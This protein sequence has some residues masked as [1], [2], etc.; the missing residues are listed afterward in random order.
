MKSIH[1]LRRGRQ[2]VPRQPI[3]VALSA[4]GLVLLMVTA[5]ACGGAG[6]TS[7]STDGPN[8][9]PQRGG[10]LRVMQVTEPRSLDP[11][12]VVNAQG[13]GEVVANSLY[14]T[15]VTNDPETGD[16]VYDMAES[17]ESTDG[18]TSWV[19]KI[20]PGIEFSDGTPYDAEAVRYNWERTKDPA[21]GS[22]YAQHAAAIAK[23]TVV[24]PHT[25]D[26]T[27]T[28]PQANFDAGLVTNNLGW[29]ASPAA[30]EKGTEAFDDNPIGAGPFTLKAWNR[31]GAMEL[32]RNDNYYDQP[33]PHLD[34]ITVTTVAEPAQR[35]DSVVA[36]DADMAPASLPANRAKAEEAGLQLHSTPGNGAA[37][38]LLNATKA[39]FD[40]IRAREA[41]VKAIDMDE[42]NIAVTQG[43][44][45]IAETL[46]SKGQQLWSDVSLHDTDKKRAQELFDELAVEGKPLEF[47]ITAANNANLAEAAQT[48]L[49]SFDNITVEVEKV[50]TGESTTRPLNGNY[51]ALTNGSIFADPDSWLMTWYH[52]SSGFNVGKVA[53][54]ELDALIEKARTT[55]D[56]AER[57]ALLEQAQQVIVEQYS[58]LWTVRAERSYI[59]GANVGGI[60]T[61]GNASAKT[62]ELW[63]G[64]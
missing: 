22:P 1:P 39:P 3:H 25:L 17:L 36:G 46:I 14:G 13:F 18:G 63:L 23:M 15:L 64:E 5:A 8:G 45:E 53:D 42:L 48:Q 26:F 16:L 2:P 33:R 44:G 6:S 58:A 60:V 57:R 43:H 40:D 35:L 54:P 7:A 56:T 11:A 30:L 20:K 19:L 62:D 47:T 21:L 41:I 52:S 34:G 31:G 55:G 59:A 50:E 29:I 38:I 61:Y 9:E 27:L 12:T 37:V 28:S 51:Q 24:D 49:R 4:A 32:V 10:V